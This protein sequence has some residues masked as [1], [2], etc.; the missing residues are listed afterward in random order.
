MLT[1]TRENP[2]LPGIQLDERVAATGAIADVAQAD[3][4]LLAVPAQDLRTA[5]TALA[6]QIATACRS[7][8]APR[9]SSAARTVS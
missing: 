9:A 4:I 8:P 7:S 6:P 3:A 2:R 5:A 1:T